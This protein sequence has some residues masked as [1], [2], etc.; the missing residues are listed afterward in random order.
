MIAL[1]I[2][3]LNDLDDMASFRPDYVISIVSWTALPAEIRPGWIDAARH[4]AFQF[5][6]IDSPRFA[7]APTRDDIRQIVEVGQQLAAPGA[8]TRMVIHCAAG[9]SR[10]PATGY[11]FHCIHLGAGREQEAM[12][13]TAASAVSPVVLPNTLMIN[14]ADDHL[15]R[16]GEMARV[17][18]EWHRAS[19]WS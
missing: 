16:N 7:G 13:A 6:D 1:R 8:A 4:I 15:K 19:C 17:V 9:V 2:C 14:Y 3:G 12:E 18:R 11:I 5:D 10:S